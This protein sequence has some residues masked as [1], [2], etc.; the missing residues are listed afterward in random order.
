[1]NEYAINHGWEIVETYTDVMSG[2]KASRPELNPLMADAL[3]RKFDYLLVW[4]R[5]GAQTL[6][7]EEV[8]LIE[9]GEVRP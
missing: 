1:L 5:G 4:R 9:S 2:A 3:A 6:S 7:F 8:E